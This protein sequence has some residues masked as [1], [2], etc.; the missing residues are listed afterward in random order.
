M[1]SCLPSFLIFAVKWFHSWGLSFHFVPIV[2]ELLLTVAGR[3]CLKT[4]FN[5][6]LS[7]GFVPS[8]YSI[9]FILTLIVIT[10]AIPIVRVTSF[11]FLSLFSAGHLNSFSYLT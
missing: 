11:T 2:G 6:S 8:P 4:H 9:S 3:F 1:T 5:R 10:Y 7:P